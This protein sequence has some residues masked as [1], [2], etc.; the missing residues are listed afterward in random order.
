[1]TS[2]AAAPAPTRTTRPSARPI[3][4]SRA[5]TRPPATTAAVVVLATGTRACPLA[6]AA[7]SVCATLTSSVA[8]VTLRTVR[9]C[10]LPAGSRTTRCP[11]TSPADAPGCKVSV[12]AFAAALVASARPGNVTA[13]TSE[14]AGAPAVAGATASSS[15]S[16]TRR[17]SDASPAPTV[18]RWL[19]SENAPWVFATNRSGVP[20]VAWT[21]VVV[22]VAAVRFSVTTA[23]ASACGSTSGAS[24]VSR[25][26]ESVLLTT[27]GDVASSTTRY[28]AVPTAPI[29]TTVPAGRPPVTSAVGPWTTTAPAPAAASS[30]VAKVFTATRVC[31]FTSSPAGC[32]R[33]SGRSTGT[34]HGLGVRVADPAV[35]GV[36]AVAD[37]HPVAAGEARAR[38]H[39]QGRRAGRRAGA[40][41]RRAQQCRGGGPRRDRRRTASPRPWWRPRSSTRTT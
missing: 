8:A 17:T 28:S 34:H 6:C 25:T 36:A 33:A 16:P 38:Q 30:T 9:V 39:E 14:P 12:V 41:A 35:L 29:S 18:T 2:C 31:S 21:T 3:R 22:V 20:A 7:V 40:L 27:V 15:R 26:V 1:M 10:G 13:S 4:S 5:R 37:P 19:R 32:E 23:D 11:G 24:S